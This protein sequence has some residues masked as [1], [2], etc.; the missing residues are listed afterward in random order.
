M[1]VLC[2]VISVETEQGKRFVGK[3]EYGYPFLYENFFI[4]L[5]RLSIQE[6][7]ALEYIDLLNKHNMWTL[8][9]TKRGNVEIEKVLVEFKI[10][11]REGREIDTCEQISW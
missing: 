8:L 9:N 4:L 5:V 11:T 10:I 2:Y 6:K 3:D 7:N 1:E